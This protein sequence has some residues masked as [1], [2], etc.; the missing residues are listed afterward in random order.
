MAFYFIGGEDIDFPNGILLG[1]TTNGARFRA[2]YAR[3]AL[4]SSSNHTQG[5][6]TA[7]TVFSSGAVTSLWITAQVYNNTLNTNSVIFGLGQTA[8][9]GSGLYLGTTTNS[10][11][12]LYKY[13]AAS[14]VLAPIGPAVPEGGGSGTMY[15]VDMQVTNY[16]PSAIVNVFINKSVSPTI[17][18]FGDITIPGMSGY[19]SALIGWSSNDFYVSEIMVTDFDTRS[20]IGLVTMAPNGN[21]TTQN[22]SNPDFSNFNPIVINDANATFV[23][24]T[25]Q[26]E[27]ANLIDL[28]AGSFSI[29]M[30]RAVAR[31]LATSGAATTNLSL[32]VNNAGT[33]AV[34]P[35]HT[36]TIA[37][38]PY[39][40]YMATD[41]TTGTAWVQSEMNGLQIDLRSA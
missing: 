20:L 23:N 39:E 40:D 1:V 8:Q 30:V 18:F 28:P 25:A 3:C 41:P 27:Q 29:P 36:L 5:A 17:S 15:R 6:F 19:D 31:A 35:P 11:L 2:G 13:N 14:N 10:V 16:G 21:G 7:S 12:Q 34:R 33:V 37:F 32:G 38:A 24:T 9:S 26:D 22:W 4:A